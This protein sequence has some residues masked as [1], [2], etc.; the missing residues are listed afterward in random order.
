MPNVNYFKVHSLTHSSS[1]YVQRRVS[2]RGGRCTPTAVPTI[3]GLMWWGGGEK[4][5]VRLF[6]VCVF[7]Q[8]LQTTCRLYMFMYI[9]ILCID[10]RTKR[11][12]IP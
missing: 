2:D 6:V 9:I 8:T 11:V 5:F 7:T 12:T 3:N 1:A 4:G 10:E